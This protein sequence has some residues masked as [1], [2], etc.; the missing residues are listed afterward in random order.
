[1]TKTHTWKN[2]HE[3]IAQASHYHIGTK[4]E[5]INERIIFSLK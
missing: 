5:L 1:M 3:R 4:R 2:H